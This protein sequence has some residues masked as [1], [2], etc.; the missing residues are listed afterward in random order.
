MNDDRPSIFL[1]A[2]DATCVLPSRRTAVPS[3]NNRHTQKRKHRNNR[4]TMN[5]RRRR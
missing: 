2:I 3:A 5:Y 4:R 1:P